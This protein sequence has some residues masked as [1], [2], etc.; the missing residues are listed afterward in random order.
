LLPGSRYCEADRLSKTAW[1]LFGKT[2]LGRG[3]CEAICDYVHQHI[4]F[5]YG[6]AR[7]RRTARE[8]SLLRSHTG[9]CRDYTHLAVALCRCMT[10][11]ARYCTAPVISATS[12]CRLRTRRWFRSLVRSLSRWRVVSLRRAQQHPAHRL[13]AD[14]PRSRWRRTSRSAGVLV[15][16]RLASSR[17]GPKKSQR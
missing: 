5:G 2:P 6:H 16:T 4:A 8:R 10:I 3:R 15:R 7:A 9:V 1:S 14:R 17:Y 11:P 12:A 13:G